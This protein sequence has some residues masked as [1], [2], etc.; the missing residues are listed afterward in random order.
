[1]T[2]TELGWGK[3]AKQTRLGYILAYKY[4]YDR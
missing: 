2:E 1:M 4:V 3:N